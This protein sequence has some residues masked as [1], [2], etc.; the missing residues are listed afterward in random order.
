ME[1]TYAKLQPGEVDS[2]KSSGGDIQQ[3]P[4]YIAV[5]GKRGLL[6]RFDLDD[7]ARGTDYA[8]ELYRYD[9]PWEDRNVFAT[10][11][12]KPWARELMR[13]L[14]AWENCRL[15]SAARHSLP[16][17]QP[18][19]H[20]QPQ[21]AI[22]S[23]AHAERMAWRKTL[24]VSAT[25]AALDPRRYGDPLRHGTRR[26]ARPA[27]T[28]AQ[29]GTVQRTSVHRDG[30]DGRRVLR[31]ARDDAAGPADGRPRVRRT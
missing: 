26:V 13:R 1:H 18:L 16:S 22:R 6:A 27:V 4:S 19:I 31:A 29:Q 9:V 7:S 30:A 21:A 10:D 25:L 15:R 12:D 17:P 11:H 14:R 2:D 24:G 3:V 23:D 8:W 28:Q 20:Q 5:R